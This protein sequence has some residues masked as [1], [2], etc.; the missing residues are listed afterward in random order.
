MTTPSLPD[1]VNLQNLPEAEL[2][3]AA[4]ALTEKIQTAKSDEFSQ[5]EKSIQEITGVEDKISTD[6][7]KAATIEVIDEKVRD[8]LQTDA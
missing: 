5:M 3:P 8:I 7:L 2:M 6:I 1:P 4:Q